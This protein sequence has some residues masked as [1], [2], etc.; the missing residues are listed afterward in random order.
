MNCSFTPHA[1]YLCMGVQYCPC[2]VYFY[3]MLALSA[4]CNNTDIRLV[5]GRSNLE[6]RVEVCFQRQ[7]GTVCDDFWDTKDAAVVC[8]QLGLNTE[9]KLRQIRYIVHVVYTFSP[10]SPA[11]KC[12]KGSQLLF[13]IHGD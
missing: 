12:L 5:G 7:W 10:D 1:V 11:Y 9:C 2:F 13:H 4:G 3:G 6:G 8:R